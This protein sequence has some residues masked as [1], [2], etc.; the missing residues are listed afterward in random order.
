M[1]RIIIGLQSRRFS[2]GVAAPIKSI[3]QG[4]KCQ[5]VIYVIAD[6]ESS[7]ETAFDCEHCYIPRRKRLAGIG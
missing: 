5:I 3:K 7:N 2:W 6:F 1:S 4:K